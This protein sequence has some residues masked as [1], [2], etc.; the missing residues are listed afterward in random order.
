M[1][2]LDSWKESYAMRIEFQEAM[3]N[4]QKEKGNPPETIDYSKLK[5]PNRKNSKI[6]V[7]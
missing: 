3:I 1:N 5:Y 2:L 7:K 4:H 6:M